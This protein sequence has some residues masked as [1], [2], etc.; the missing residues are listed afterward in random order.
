MN[1][2]FLK[3]VA[4]DLYH[5]VNGDLSRTAVIFPGKRAGLFFNDYLADLAES[6]PVWA[7][8]YMTI[9]ELFLSLAEGW[10]VA[11]PIDAVMRII[12]IYRD[13]LGPE[14]AAALNVEWFYGWAE[15][16]LADFDDV[17]KNLAPADALFRHIAEWRE[18]DTLDYLTDEQKEELRR[19]FNGFDADQRGL[20]HEQFQKLWDHLG[21]M[22]QRLNES[23]AAEGLAYEG[24]LFR[25]VVDRLHQGEVQLDPNIDHYAIVGFNVLDKVERELFAHLR[26]E[27]KAWFYWDY[28]T[29]YT[30][31]RKGLGMHEAGEFLRQN[32]KNF[33][34]E[35]PKHLFD[36]LR[37]PRRIEMVSAATEAIQ[38]RYVGPWLNE[39]LTD[40]A[41]RTAVVLCNE[42]ILQSVLHALPDSIHELNVT[43]GFPLSHTEAATVVERKFSEWERR[44]IKQEEKRV[45]AGQD[46]KIPDLGELL[47]SLIQHVDEEGRKYVNREGYD[48]EQ[49]EDIL[50]GEAYYLLY[51]LLNRFANIIAK[52]ADLEL[53]LVTLRRLVRGVV[54]QQSVPFHGEPAV[55]L[56]IMGVLETRCLDF[57][58]IIMLS[59]GDGL[60]PQKVNDNSFIPYLLR[61]SYELTTPERKTAVYAYY[62]Y[63]LLQRASHITLTYN[64]S[65]EG[66]ATGEMSRFMTQLLVEWPGQ[67]HHYTLSSDQQTEHLAPREVPKPDDLILRLSRD[68]E[69]PMA[70]FSPTSLSNYLKC[71]LKFYFC[72]VMK[73]RE[74]EEEDEDE[75]SQRFFGTL[76]HKCAEIVYGDIISSRGG[77]VTQ[78]H[79]LS[80]AKD[81]RFIDK[82][83]RQ[84]FAEEEI[85][86]RVLEGRVI[87]MYLKN[88]LRF[89]ARFCP[90]RVEQMEASV[91]CSFPVTVSGQDLNVRL[92]GQID[93]VDIVNGT[94][95]IVDFK[96]G[97][98]TLSGGSV[99]EIKANDL[100]AIFSRS[101]PRGYV[102]QTFLYGTII[103]HSAPHNAA[104]ARWMQHPLKPVLYY[105]RFMSNPNYDPSTYLDK[106]PVNDVA[107]YAE[108]FEQLL[109]EVIE[110]IL[111]K[112][113][114][115]CPAQDHKQCDKCGYKSICWREKA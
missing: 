32:M 72:N 35:L 70:R 86:Y 84:A 15:R 96:T 24:A 53:G 39:H 91:G 42:A 36:N 9:N 82:V 30:D 10:T 106:H 114:P 49:F 105:T 104:A 48:A 43:K 68:V 25:R 31:P 58:N 97:Y 89:D 61:K 12:K 2:T 60:L 14:E 66:M 3:H 44:Y 81:K 95:R 115:F 13:S 38:A 52:H 51:T 33:P 88:L 94:V 98:A 29:Y 83:V 75:L 37:K 1:D 80:L 55:G 8:R 45:K 65:T 6:A 56:Q 112:N 111:D 18:F 110:E 22:Y 27:E 47:R 108:E 77:E 41:R 7:P 64:T 92:T 69:H 76:F 99:Q 93:R 21:E 19:F 26:G 20:L 4:T 5:K 85:E 62:F 17:D 59:A 102:L 74:P 46:S 57:E 100:P 103:R 50:Q 23:L 78:D 16:I 79:I 40:D 34:G 87:G 11:D 107:P 101:K 73:I 67:V 113:T 54:R 71:P 63:R 90:F 109:R 28:D